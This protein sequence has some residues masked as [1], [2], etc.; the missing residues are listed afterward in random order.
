MF[1]SGLFR[2]SFSSQS[3]PNKETL[4]YSYD[5]S[6]F[7][8]WF[9]IFV[10]AQGTYWTVTCIGYLTALQSTELEASKELVGK[11]YKSPFGSGDSAKD[12]DTKTDELERDDGMNRGDRQKAPLWARVG[13]ASIMVLV[14]TTMGCIGWMY[15]RRNVHYLSSINNGNTL[16]V[17]VYGFMGKKD[18]F[19][20]P[21][22]D[23]RA[24]ELLHTKSMSRYASRNV[25]T[26]AMRENTGGGSGYS[27]S[28]PRGSV[29]IKITG[30]SLYYK[31]DKKG[32]FP[33]PRAFNMLMQ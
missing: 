6:N 18:F 3:I 28:K 19:H 32:V 17:G 11:L 27:G 1:L 4:L 33:S 24:M 10:I 29:M 20:V 16:K 9:D 23:C 2:R 25:S 22:K 26:T 21:T 12:K 15:P 14:G 31:M 8:K 30:K 5:R 7:F 13:I